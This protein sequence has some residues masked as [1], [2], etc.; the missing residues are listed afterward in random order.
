MEW[1]PARPN[2]PEVGGATEIGLLERRICTT[3]G[4]QTSAGRNPGKG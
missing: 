1:G 4:Q 2:A 3:R